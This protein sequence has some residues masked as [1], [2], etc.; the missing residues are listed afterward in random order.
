MTIFQAS[1]ILEPKPQPKDTVY[2]PRPHQET[3]T[4][5][6]TNVKP[7]SEIKWRNLIRQ[8]YD[9]SCGSAALSTL[10]QFYINEDIGELKVMR[11]MLQQGERQKIIQRQGFS[12]L[13]M[14]RYVNYLGYEGNGFRAEIADLKEL[15]RPVLIPIE[16]G[17]FKHF[18]VLRKLTERRAFLGDPAFGNI[19]LTITKFKQIWEPDVLF[20]A[21][22]GDRVGMNKLRLNDEDLRNTSLP[23]GR[24]DE[25]PFARFNLN[26]QLKDATDRALRRNIVF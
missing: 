13:D 14:K 9:F 8:R 20:M 18:V 10:L 4:I 24:D 23:A 17:G 1:Y 26:E 6:S 19:S 21:N 3:Q 2:L 12:L 5:Q 16:Y 15:G 25:D 11:G 7:F 22:R